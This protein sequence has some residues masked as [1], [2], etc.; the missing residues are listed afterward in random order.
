LSKV[1]AVETRQWE[2]YFK[3]HFQQTPRQWLEERRQNEALRLLALDLRLELMAK[4]L[5]IITRGY[6][7]FVLARL[8]DRPVLECRMRAK[9]ARDPLDKPILPAI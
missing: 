9:P 7:Y 4:Q 5:G 1:Y 2:R 3:R 6:L 8:L